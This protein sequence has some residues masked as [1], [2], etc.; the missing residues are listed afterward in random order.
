VRHRPFVS[1]VG[2]VFFDQV[3]LFYCFVLLGSLLNPKTIDD[4]DWVDPLDEHDDD[5]ITAD[6]TDATNVYEDLTVKFAHATA[7]WAVQVMLTLF[8]V[9]ELNTNQDTKDVNKVDFIY[10]V[11]AVVFQINGGEAELGETFNSK[12]WARV[13]Q[14][15]GFRN[16]MFQ[17]VRRGSAVGVEK[18]WK[19]PLLWAHSS[20]EELSDARRKF[21]LNE[22]SSIE[23]RYKE[24]L[25]GLSR[26]KHKVF[27]C[28]DMT[29]QCEWLLRCLLDFSVNSVARST[30]LYTVP[31]MVCVEGPLDFVKDLTAVMF[32][33]LLDNINRE[34]ELCEILV[35]L[36]FGFDMRAHKEDHRVD[37]RVASRVR[38]WFGRCCASEAS[39][40]SR[41][42]SLDLTDWEK[43]Y[44]GDEANRE[45]FE[46]FALLVPHEWEAFLD[47]C[48][49]Y[50][51]Q[52][53]KLVTREDLNLVMKELTEQREM[54]LQLKE[55]AVR[56]PE[57]AATDSVGP[58][59]AQE[60]AAEERWLQTEVARQDQLHLV[61]RDMS[62]LKRMVQL[63]R[64][65]Q[66]GAAS[67]MLD[68]TGL[69]G[70]RLVTADELNAVVLEM[71]ELGRV[72]AQLSTE[73]EGRGQGGA[74]QAGAGDRRCPSSGGVTASSA[75]N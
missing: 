71:L 29:L 1:T 41:S 35:K 40:P 49:V 44:V 37:R 47:R 66:G 43:E 14:L 26:M 64:G 62:P 55:A 11:V 34:K 13:L 9:E 27:T 33:T 52:A 53:G 67:D 50:S 21:K 19:Q 42:G 23:A 30:I 73:F 48:G 25:D 18:A 46:R 10:W 56:D 57:G 8:F 70:K 45:R 24:S 51:S 63:W 4:R 59:R 39:L 60:T 12:Y 74:H 5:S 16:W 3:V 68:G 54:M 2:L 6:R 75:V 20:Q 69:Q 72:V 7:I 58:Q 17:K 28:F 31:I 15:P 36:K 38:S 61:Q 22:R 65:R 32:I